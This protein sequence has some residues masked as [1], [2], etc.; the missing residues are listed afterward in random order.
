MRGFWGRVPE[1]GNAT[2]LSDCAVDEVQL[3]DLQRVANG[4]NMRMSEFSRACLR[5]EIINGKRALGLKPR[6]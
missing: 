1:K 4:Y 2:A 6:S 3:Q 5:K